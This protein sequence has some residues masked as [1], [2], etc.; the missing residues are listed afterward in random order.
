MTWIENLAGLSKGTA[1]SVYSQNGEEGVLEAIFAGIGETNRFLVD[2][3]AG[4]GVALSNTRLFIERGWTG[5]RFD[6][7]NGE[8]VHQECVTAEN[9]SSL[10]AKYRVPRDFDLL[11]LDIDGV[12]WWVLRSILRGGYYPR[13]MCVEV[14]PGLP[15]EPPVAIEYDPAFVNSADDY[16]GASLSAFIMLAESYGYTLVHLPHFNAFFVRSELLPE[17]AAASVAHWKVYPCWPPDKQHR[18]WHPITEDD[19]R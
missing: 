1:R 18:P 4:D 3:G 19:L 6:V 8:G 14:N 5:A 2:I 10:L 7:K 16:F 17:D 12:D 11:S 15:A 9:V 13:V